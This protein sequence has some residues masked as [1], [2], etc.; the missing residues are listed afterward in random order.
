MSVTDNVD[1]HLSIEPASM[2][3]VPH[4]VL[5]TS[6]KAT[7]IFDSVGANQAGNT[8]NSTRTVIVEAPAILNWK[9]R[10]LRCQKNRPTLPTG[11]SATRFACAALCYA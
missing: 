4:I 9:L 3:R 2:A 5:D 8:A 7:D 11:P 1:D 10:I 6:S